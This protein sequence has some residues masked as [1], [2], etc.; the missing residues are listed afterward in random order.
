M[1]HK[2]LLGGIA[3]L[4]LGAAFTAPAQAA[5]VLDNGT[6]QIGVN[7]LGHLNVP[8][9]PVGGDPL[10]LGVLGLRY[11][12]TGAASTEPG[13]ACEGWGVSNGTV[14]GFANESSGTAGLA[15]EDFTS[16]DAF[17][18]NAKSV[19]MA[20][21]IF[22]VTHDYKPSASAN[23]YQVDVTI[24]NI[25]GSDQTALYRRVMDWDIYPTPFSEFVT[26]VNSSPI[27]FRTDTNGFN[28]SDPLT[29]GSFAVGPSASNG[30]TNIID[31]GP[32]DHGALFDFDF[33]TLAAAASMS[34]TTFYGAGADM[35]E[36][37]AALTAVG[38][39]N[40][41]SLGK[42]SCTACTIPGGA[43]NTFVFGFKGVGGTVVGG[44]VP[45]PA[46]LTLL[47]AGLAGIG[48]LRRRKA[49]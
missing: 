23:L 25:S 19:V 5:A 16:T 28:S 10:G 26:I 9:A 21:G 12:P 2:T 22:R 13:C 39:E 15:L 30:Y 11:K 20:A 35:A 1:F 32:S 6:I 4:A 24:E 36:V 49:A 42:A 43:P 34:F 40:V 47:G 37:I 17:V 8:Y 45:E 46:T 14:S 48:A 7:D 38:A 44:E 31:S 18:T 27:V 3:A 33:G 29:F 41:Y